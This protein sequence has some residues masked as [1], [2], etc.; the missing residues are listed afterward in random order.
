MKKIYQIDIAQEIYVRELIKKGYTEDAMA[1]LAEDAMAECGEVLTF[2][3]LATF[4][5]L[6][7]AEKEFSKYSSDSTENYSEL[8][9][10]LVV[11]YYLAETTFDEDGDEID[12]KILKY[13]FGLEY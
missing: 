4:D 12:F 2:Y 13:S 11:K 5:S 6:A 3:R 9:K 10:P 8:G 7:E 1:I